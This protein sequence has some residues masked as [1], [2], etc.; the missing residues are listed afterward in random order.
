MDDIILE[1]VDDNDDSNEF[2]HSYFKMLNK[3]KEK[4][5]PLMSVIIGM[6]EQITGKT[7]DNIVVNEIGNDTHTMSKLKLVYPSLEKEYNKMIENEREQKHIKSLKKRVRTSSRKVSPLDTYDFESRRC[8]DT[9]FDY[10]FERNHPNSMLLFINMHGGINIENNNAITKRCTFLNKFSS[11]G[12]GQCAF[13]ANDSSKYIAYQL[14]FAVNNFHYALDIDTILRESIAHR[15]MTHN[16]TQN[17]SKLYETIP[18]PTIVQ[19][20]AGLDAQLKCKD[21][22]FRQ[23]KYRADKELGNETVVGNTYTDKSYEVANNRSFYITICKEW[24]A[25]G[26]TQMDNLLENKVF[27]DF[28]IEKYYPSEGKNVFDRIKLTKSMRDYEVDVAVVGRVLLSDIIDF[29]EKYDRPYI[30]MLD[31]SCSVFFGQHPYT[32]RQ[33]A[34]IDRK[35]KE[36]G[37][38][39]AKG[40][41]IKRR[42]QK[43]NRKKTKGRKKLTKRK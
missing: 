1:V 34:I 16:T 39:I 3:C 22:N 33:V 24:P 8:A 20:D 43:T 32:D 4:N 13:G 42:R 31:N 35:I 2:L 27:Q 30:S 18:H 38:N 7:I 29:C 10:N 14:C 17:P 6:T 23:V 11:S 15:I 5:T 41:K 36:L 28:I 25:I 40:G 37:P 21:R 26:A 12:V 19:R 9:V